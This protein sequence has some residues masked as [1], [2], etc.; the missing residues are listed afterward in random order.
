MGRESTI[1]DTSSDIS[2]ESFT[3]GLLPDE[4]RTTSQILRASNVVYSDVSYADSNDDIEYDKNK[5]SS[6]KRQ[7]HDC[8]SW[9]EDESTSDGSDSSDSEIAVDDAYIDHDSAESELTAE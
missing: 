5:W 1:V 4:P 7:A 9:K 2:D 3:R 6:V 8:A